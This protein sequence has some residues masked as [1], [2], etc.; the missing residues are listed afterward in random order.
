LRQFFEPHRSVESAK[1]VTYR[2]TVRSRGFGF[3]EMSNNSDADS[4]VVALNGREISRR[5]IVVTEARAKALGFQS[6]RSGSRDARHRFQS[7]TSLASRSRTAE[8]PGIRQA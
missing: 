2:D 6:G 3:A 5:T 1:L 4:A 7:E 8:G